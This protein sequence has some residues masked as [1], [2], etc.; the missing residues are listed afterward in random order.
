MN[1]EIFI[2]GISFLVIQFV[3]SAGIFVKFSDMQAYA[4]S[5]DQFQLILDDLKD[6]KR[7]QSIILTELTRNKG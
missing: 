5:K 6:I 3:V 2:A 1:K 7:S 4:V